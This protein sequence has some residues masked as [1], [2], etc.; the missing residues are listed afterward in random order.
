M[1]GASPETV[2]V[3]VLTN[4]R[5]NATMHSVGVVP[6]RMPDGNTSP[7][8]PIVST[9]PALQAVAGRLL[10]VE[11]AS[12]GAARFVFEGEQLAPVEDALMEVLALDDL[13]RSPP[14]R[15]PSPSGAVTYPRWGEVYYVAGQ[16]FDTEHKRY[17]VV[18]NDR[19]NR[20]DGTAIAVRTTTQARRWGAA[21]PDIQQGV[22]RACC[23]DAT[24]FAARRF[25]LR[26]RPQ[27][28][29]LPLAD[30]T[31]IARGLVETHQLH[32]AVERHR[33]GLDL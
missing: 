16:R 17:V 23:G 29:W 4:N 19:W 31:A 30:M 14:R 25:I 24:A 33:L 15:P 28:A 2:A 26:T 7:L 9:S 21:F 5:W 22:A 12:L 13:F 32:A 20:A 27:P 11:K 18:S 6:L 3:L 10:V 8:A 1:D